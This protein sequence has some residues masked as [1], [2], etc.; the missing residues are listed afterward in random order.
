MRY[1]FVK[2]NNWVVNDPAVHG[3]IISYSRNFDFGIL[4]S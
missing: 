3:D 2:I 4:F 1:W